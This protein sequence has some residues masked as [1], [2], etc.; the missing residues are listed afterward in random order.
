MIRLISVVRVHQEG[1]ALA[2]VAH[3]DGL[4]LGVSLER[5]DVAIAAGVYQVVAHDSPRF[6]RTTI[7]LVVPTR[8]NILIHEGNEPD[9]SDGCLMFGQVRDGWGRIRRSKSLVTWLERRVLP[10][11][12]GGAAWWCH[13]GELRIPVDGEIPQSP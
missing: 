2:G 13:V 4:S 1:N 6:K 9:D 11:L 7:Q 5:L 8:R 10:S 3:L 12:A